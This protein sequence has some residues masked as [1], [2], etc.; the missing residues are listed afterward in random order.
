M[1]RCFFFNKNKRSF[2]MSWFHDDDGYI[3]G[4]SKPSMFVAIEENDIVP[5]EIYS[6]LVKALENSNTEKLKLLLEAGA[7]VNVKNTYGYTP[8]MKAAFYG[9]LEVVKL[10]LESGADIEAKDK[11]GWTSLMVAA[12]YGKLEVVK[13]LLEAGADIEAKDEDGWT[14]LMKATNFSKNTEVVKELLDAGA[15]VNAMNDDG[16]T[17]LM[18]AARNGNTKVAELLK[19]YGAIDLKEQQNLHEMTH[20]MHQIDQIKNERVR[21]NLYEELFDLYK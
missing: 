15:D 20:L 1:F 3:S 6:L 12:F 7:D 19:R 4:P 16:Y 14:P 13:L 2:N 17:S 18:W 11:F 8:L 10:L 21:L 9:K 5:E